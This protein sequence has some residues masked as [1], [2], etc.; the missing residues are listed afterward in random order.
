MDSISLFD[1]S[2]SLNLGDKYLN[3]YDYFCDSEYCYY[4]DQGGA[5]FSDTNHVGNYGL[6]RMRDV[7]EDLN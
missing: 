1:E 4:G 3:A 7:L 6:L 2:L 5:F